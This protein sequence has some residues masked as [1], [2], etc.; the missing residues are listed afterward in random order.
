[1][2]KAKGLRRALQKHQA[3]V[4]KHDR[5]KASLQAAK[6]KA[7]AVAGDRSRNKKN[8]KSVKKESSKYIVP[9][10]QDDSLLLLGEGTLS[11]LHNQSHAS[12]KLDTQETSL[13]LNL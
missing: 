10:N 4:Y 13:S 12:L 7:V 3:K 2:A 8:K 9:F 1:M 11:P 5:A 6:Q